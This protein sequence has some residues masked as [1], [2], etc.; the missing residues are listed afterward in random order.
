MISSFFLYAPPSRSDH[1]QIKK[2]NE[3]QKAIIE[4]QAKINQTSRIG[5]GQFDQRGL[6]G[7]EVSVKS[8]INPSILSR[9]WS[10]RGEFKLLSS[11]LPNEKIETEILLNLWC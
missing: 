3:S 2:I 4:L 8:K 1:E 11:H 9:T 7:V 5:S 6:G 10:L